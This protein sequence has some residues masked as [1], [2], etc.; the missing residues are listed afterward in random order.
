MN[1]KIIFV[2][3]IENFVFM[4]TDHI[5][6]LRCPY[7]S[8]LTL[9]D[10]RQFICKNPDRHLVLMPATYP[11]DDPYMTNGEYFDSWNPN[12][13][14]G[15]V[16]GENITDCYGEIL[17]NEESY[18]KYLSRDLVNLEDDKKRMIFSNFNGIPDGFKDEEWLYN[19]IED[20]N[21]QFRLNQKLTSSTID[22]K[23]KEI[24]KLYKKDNNLENYLGKKLKDN[25]I[26]IIRYT[27][28]FASP[29]DIY[30]DPLNDLNNTL[31]NLYG[32]IYYLMLQENLDWGNN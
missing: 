13:I 23:I 5:G 24:K 20:E 25:E 6:S 16:N 15:N 17:D 11:N 12:K 30:I 22:K 18:E 4:R 21:I 10:A 31:G 32:N 3:D 7:E 28:K 9:E 19:H 1:L 27:N 29:K 14:W 2:M 8:F 26:E